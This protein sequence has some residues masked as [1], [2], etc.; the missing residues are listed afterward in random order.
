MDLMLLRMFQQETLAQCSYV[1]IAANQ[2]NQLTSTGSYDD[3]FWREVQ[4]FVVSTGNI[5]KLLWGQRGKLATERK[6]LRDSIGVKESSPLRRT[7]LRNDFD[8]IYERMDR[9][10]AK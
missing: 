3:A 9:W 7:T 10:S 8:P 5:S 4:T 6:P 1:L 2:I